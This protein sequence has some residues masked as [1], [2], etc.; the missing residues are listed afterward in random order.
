MP[1][2][3]RVPDSIADITGLQAVLDGKLAAADYLTHVADTAAHGA[4]SANT[5][6]RI[7]SRGAAGEFAAG[8][9]TT[10]ELNTTGGGTGGVRVTSGIYMPQ[11][12]PGLQIFNTSDQVT[13]YEKLRLRY[14][15]SVSGFAVET[16]SGGTATPRPLTLQAVT[17]AGVARLLRLD[18]TNLPHI[19]GALGS[20]ATAG[21]VAQFDCTSTAS[22]GAHTTFLVAPTIN[23]TGDAAATDLKIN[24]TQTAVGSGEQLLL[25][26]QVGGASKFKVD[27]TGLV[28]STKLSVLSS[29]VDGTSTTGVAVIQGVDSY[30]QTIVY[31]APVA[32][33]SGYIAQTYKGNG[34]FGAGMLAGV[35]FASNVPTQFAVLNGSAKE[36]LV[37]KPDGA[38]LM[39]RGATDGTDYMPTD[40]T[41]STLQVNGSGKFTEVIA[42]SVRSA[43]STGSVAVFGGSAYNNGGYFAVR[44]NSYAT[45]SQRGQV[46]FYSD[47]SDGNATAGEIWFGSHSAGSSFATNVIISKSG[48]VGI[49][50]SSSGH[51]LHVNGNGVFEGAL[52]ATALYTQDGSPLTLDPYGSITVAQDGSGVINVPSV[53]CGGTVNANASYTCNGTQVVGPQQGA[54]PDCDPADLTS[55][56]NTLNAVLAAMRAHGLISY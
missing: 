54:I 55:V 14:V 36:R 15:S 47:R 33:Y 8:L 25:D 2:A 22:T 31:Q 7:V 42:D 23:Q 40:D 6:S 34:A 51:K 45:P 30:G 4:T 53:N 26:A 3:S 37:V 56:G 44:G 32:G 41:V 10:T 21:I 28:T 13:N 19:R 50:L 20:V 12:S 46:Q 17:N 38:V 1:T 11:L 43:S 49:G 16:Q 18:S 27:T 9:I 24:R 48:N 35:K 5:A 29:A 52:N 39:G